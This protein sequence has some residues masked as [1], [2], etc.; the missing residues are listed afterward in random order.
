MINKINVSDS[1]SKIKPLSDTDIDK[2]KTYLSTE[3]NQIVS[4][5]SGDYW[6]EIAPASDCELCIN[7]IYLSN[8]EPKELMS[9]HNVM[10]PPSLKLSFW[11]SN[12]AC[13]FTFRINEGSI[14]EIAIFISEIFINLF[15]IDEINMF[16]V[17]VEPI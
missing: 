14:N 4:F 2:I 10:I 1:I 15:D 3:D 11:E 12:L 6:F 8:K 16:T 7:F 13:T 9:L 17:Q 5:T